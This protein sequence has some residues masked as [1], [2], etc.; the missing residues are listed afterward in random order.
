[1]WK[2]ILLLCLL[3]FFINSAQAG[4][5]NDAIQG[6]NATGYWSQNPP[7]TDIA[8]QAYGV[9]CPKGDALSAFNY[10]AGQRPFLSE[11]TP[12]TCSTSSAFSINLDQFA[13]Q[14]DIVA[15]QTSLG[16]LGAQLASESEKLSQALRYEARFSRSGVAQALAMAGTTD[17]QPDEHYAIS[18]N[19]GLFGGRAAVASGAAM[20]M[21]DHVSINGGFTADVNGG[22]VGARAGVRFGW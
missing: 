19:I 8:L 9:E 13:R 14:S 7:T 18:M 12:S 20:R 6:A 2:K 10:G 1:M 11:W 4:Q 22:A 21:S 3:A 15:L 16:A 5:W 17:L